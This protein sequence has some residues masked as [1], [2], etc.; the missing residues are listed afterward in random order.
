MANAQLQLITIDEE[1]WKLDARTIR[2]G[3]RG[4]AKARAALA[5]SLKEE[6]DRASRHQADAA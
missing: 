5:Q 2:V 1:L 6:H 4:L 3:R